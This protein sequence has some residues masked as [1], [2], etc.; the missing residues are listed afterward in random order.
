MAR[1]AKVESVGTERDLTAGL[2]REEEVESSEGD[3]ETPSESGG[4]DQAL[5]YI[6]QFSNAVKLY[7]KKNQNCFG[8]GSPDHLVK[9]CPMDLSKVTRKVSLNAKKGMAKKGSWTPQKPVVTQLASPD[10]ALRA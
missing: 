6:I 8:C 1:S 3:P 5:S 10:E 4:A 9:D 2:E 7:Q